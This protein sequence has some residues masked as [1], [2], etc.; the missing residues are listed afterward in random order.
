MALAI[1]LVLTAFP[2]ANAVQPMQLGTRLNDRAIPSE[3]QVPDEMARHLRPDSLF[4]VCPVARPRTYVDSFGA[5]RYSGGFHRHEGIDI[6]APRATRIL[7]PFDGRAKS[8]TSWNG[9][10]QVYVYGQN[11]FVFNSHLERAGK[12][13]KVHA[14]DVVGYVGSSGNAWG[15]ATHDHFEWH[16]RGGAAVDP[17]DMLNQVCRGRPRHKTHQEGQ[18]AG[19]STRPT[20]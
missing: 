3:D 6:M 18:T 4:Q 2:V 20:L 16:P 1:G 19:P 10:L 9:G 11:G 8:S 7:A 15:G 17:F 13:G 12:M 14:G 5:A